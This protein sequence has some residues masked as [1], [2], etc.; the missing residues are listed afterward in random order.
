M[1]TVLLKLQNIISEINNP[2][3]AIGSFIFLIVFY[4]FIIPCMHEGQKI[5]VVICVLDCTF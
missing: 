4:L 2:E 5:V 3:Y 1:F